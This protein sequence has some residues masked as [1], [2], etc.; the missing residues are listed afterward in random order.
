MIIGGFKNKLSRVDQYYMVRTVRSKF[1]SATR[2][3]EWGSPL[4]FVSSKFKGEVRRR[5]QVFPGNRNAEG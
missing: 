5:K 3:G 4:S 1:Y 2:L